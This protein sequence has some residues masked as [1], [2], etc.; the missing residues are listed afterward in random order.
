MANASDPLAIDLALTDQSKLDKNI[1]LIQAISNPISEDGAIVFGSIHRLHA[2]VL[3]GL[4][5]KMALHPVQFPSG[6]KNSKR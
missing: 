5:G 6:Q 4:T 2:I 3:N 1:I